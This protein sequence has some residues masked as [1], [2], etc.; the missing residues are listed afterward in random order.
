MTGSF[1]SAPLSRSVPAN[2]VK[3]AFQALPCFLSLARGPAETTVGTRKSSF[4]GRHGLG[5]RE[6]EVELDGDLFAT[7]EAPTQSRLY[8]HALCGLSYRLACSWGSAACGRSLRRC[9]LLGCGLLLR[10]RFG[11]GGGCPLANRSVLRPGAFA[12]GET[13]LSRLVRSR[14]ADWKRLRSLPFAPEPTVLS[15]AMASLSL[16]LLRERMATLRKLPTGFLVA[17]LLFHT[18]AQMGKSE[19]ETLS[20][21]LTGLGAV[22]LGFL[23]AVFFGGLGFVVRLLWGLVAGLLLRSFGQR[24]DLRPGGLLARL[25]LDGVEHDDDARELGLVARGGDSPPGGVDGVGPPVDGSVPPGLGRLCASRP[26]SRGAGLDE[27]SLAA[28]R[29]FLYAAA[30]CHSLPW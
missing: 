4:G 23:G 19:L 29:L 13:D 17:H 12:R 1:F 2:L 15:R 28:A 26:V 30:R 9:P 21:A 20:L 16:S 6:H 3:N 7:L 27:L 10:L 14:A 5:L 24:L 25:R 11:L 18:D 22:T 8:A